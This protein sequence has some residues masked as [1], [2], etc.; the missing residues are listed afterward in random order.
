VCGGF[1]WVCVCECMGVFMGVYVCVGV[2]MGVYV[3]VGVCMGVC[4]GGCLYG[5]VCGGVCVLCSYGGEDVTVTANCEDV[6]N[7]IFEVLKGVL[8]NIQLL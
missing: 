3:C 1:V 7:A 8:L 5:C 4:V 6:T 2:C